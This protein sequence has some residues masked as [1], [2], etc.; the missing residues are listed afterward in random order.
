MR[1]G[2]A[3]IADRSHAR[4]AHPARSAARAA[5]H[6]VQCK[7]REDQRA[8]DNLRNQGFE[9]FAPACIVERRLRQSLVRRREPLFPGYA[10]VELNRIEHNWGV[11]R[12]TRGVARLV[13]FGPHAATV[14]AAV[15]AALR[16]VDGT[17]IRQM[18]PRLTPGD[19]V[20]IIDGPFTDLEAVFEQTDGSA[21]VRVLIDLMHRQVP[22]R[23]QASAIAPL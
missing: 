4:A 11:L 23:V 7:P 5:W 18:L 6:V 3:P 9:T 1:P 20:R 15:I 10:F 16:L 19:R 8:V 21:R 17:E 14:P 13:Q 2:N 12:S 22:I